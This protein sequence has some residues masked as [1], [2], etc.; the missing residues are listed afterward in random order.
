M[1]PTL[2]ITSKLRHP[3]NIEVANFEYLKT[4]VRE[5]PHVLSLRA[6]TDPKPLAN[7]L[8]RHT[9]ADK[10]NHIKIT[11]PSPTMCHFRGGRAAIS[12]E[13]YPDLDEFFADLAACYRA[14][15]DALYKA[16]CRYLQLDDTNLAYLT[17]ATMRKQAA[18]R[19][20][21]LVGGE[22]ADL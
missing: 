21:N 10:H 2:S 15:V 3:H 17:D 5:C 1:P 22:K 13:V 12:S 18:D 20:E 19:G 16:G 4:L 8:A 7:P 11:I 14:E 9:A 6:R